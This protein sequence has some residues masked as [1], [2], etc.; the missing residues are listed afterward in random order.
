VFNTSQDDIKNK[1]IPSMV[2]N[3]NNDLPKD[4]PIMKDEKTS[5]VISS[6]TEGLFMKDR[7]IINPRLHS[8]SSIT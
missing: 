2:R 4:S 1:P 8:D 5:S 6:D 7:R 3:L